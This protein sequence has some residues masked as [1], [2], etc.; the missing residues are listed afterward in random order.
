MTINFTAGGGDGLFDI[1]GKWFHAFK[2]LNTA[3]A[4]TVPTEVLDAILQ[5]KK[6]TASTA[7]ADA[8]LSTISGALEGWK[9]GGDSIPSSGSQFLQQLIVDIVRTDAAQPDYTF[10]QCLSYLLAAMSTQS[11][12]VEGNT[13]SS[14]L[15]A[16][17]SNSANDLV[18][19]HTVVRGD[20]RTQELAYA[21]PITFTVSSSSYRSASLGVR[22]NASTGLLSYDWPLGSGLNTSVTSVH[23]STS[24]LLTNGDFETVT[25]AN[26]PDGWTPVAG[27]VG[28]MYTITAPEQQTIVI[29]GTPTSGSYWLRWVNPDG[30]ERTSDR[31]DYNASSS[32]VE[33][34]LQ[35]ILG[36]ENV[37]VSSTG[38]S[39]NYTHTVTFTGVAGNINNLSSIN[40]LN[41]GT[42]THAQT[43]AGSD[44]AYE[45]NA[46]KITG[47]GSTQGTIYQALPVLEPDTVYFLAW[48]HKKGSTPAAGTVRFAVVDEIAGT[49]VNNSAGTANSASYDLTTTA[50]TTSYTAAWM[51]IRVPKSASQPLYLEIKQTTAI[52]NAAYYAL[53]E[54]VLVEAEQLYRGGPYVAAISGKT[55]PILTDTWTLTLS[56]DRAS[57]MQEWFGRIFGMWDREALLPVT[58]TT[59][60][61]DSL[62]A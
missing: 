42:I 27:T 18:I 29:A 30:I 20:G 48:R 49:V 36:L 50:V 32:D 8:Y 12:K 39:P 41:T 6:R 25:V 58:G 3:R 9:A 4:T 59:L 2:T 35:G 10:E 11:Y 47:N 55:A 45:G 14:S 34:A 24:N 23:A 52:S 61:P 1:L 56:N 22:S 26:L 46:L 7:N 53:D 40:A 54:M 51:A 31:L 38:T 28:T 19:A 57:E 15:A 33:S 37:S 60:L 62:I 44:D 43:V 17:G 5:Y 16:G 13:V 21:E